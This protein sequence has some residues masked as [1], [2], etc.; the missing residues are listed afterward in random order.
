MSNNDVISF[1]ETVCCA[2]FGAN[3]CLVPPES[4]EGQE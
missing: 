1:S 4:S 3:T 2:E